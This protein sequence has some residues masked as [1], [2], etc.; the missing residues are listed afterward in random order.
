MERGE[1]E[2]VAR[3]ELSVRQKMLGAALMGLTVFGRRGCR[4]FLFCVC[5]AAPRVHL[6]VCVCARVGH[7]CV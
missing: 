6:C 4:D 3:E 7:L 2:I 1:E 5:S